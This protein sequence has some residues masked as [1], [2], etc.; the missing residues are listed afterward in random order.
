MCPNV[1][2]RESSK[3]APHHKPLVDIKMMDFYV[4]ILY[5]AILLNHLITYPFVSLTLLGFSMANK[6]NSYL[7]NFSILFQWVVER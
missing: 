5:P 4:L 1:P 3:V 6:V 2:L 7:S